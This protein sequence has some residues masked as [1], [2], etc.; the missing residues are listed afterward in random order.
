MTD[1]PLP[2]GEAPTPQTLR[3]LLQEKGVTIKE[4]A[5][6]VRYSYCYLTSILSGRV[7]M[8]KGFPARFH[9]ALI[10]ALNAKRR[11]GEGQILVTRTSSRP[12]VRVETELDQSIIDDIHAYFQGGYLPELIRWIVGDWILEKKR[13]GEIPT[14]HQGAGAPSNKKRPAKTDN[15][16][17]R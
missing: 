16:A 3:A 10:D 15:P 12:G 6:L 17:G 5:P 8:P 7:Q 4:L 11:P 9:E 2:G 1:N 14:R 13:N